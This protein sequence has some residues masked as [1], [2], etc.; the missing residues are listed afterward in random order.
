MLVEVKDTKFVRDTNSMALVNK[1]NGAR[2]EYYAKVR[3]LKHQKEEI[4]NL[5]SEISSMKNDMNDIKNLLAQLI[6]KGGNG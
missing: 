2:D 5:R 1:D 6:G 3:M 4:N